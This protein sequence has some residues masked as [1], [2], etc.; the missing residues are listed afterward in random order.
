MLIH[1]NGRKC[2]RYER[3]YREKSSAV[4]CLPSTQFPPL[5]TFS[6]NCWAEDFGRGM[7]LRIFSNILWKYLCLDF[8]SLCMIFMKY[9][10][11]MWCFHFGF[12]FFMNLRMEIIFAFEISRWKG[13]LFPILSSISNCISDQK[14]LILLLIFSNYWA[15]LCAPIF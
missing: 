7:T 1:S 13:L 14:R 8:L 9:I 10:F 2:K 6:S 12:F 4:F 5:L 3:I 11:L 15:M